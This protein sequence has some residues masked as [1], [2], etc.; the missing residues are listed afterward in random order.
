MF[1]SKQYVK[2]AGL[3][4]KSTAFKPHGLNFLLFKI[5]ILLFKNKCNHNGLQNYK[6]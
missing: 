1:Y 2:H 6:L 5:Q 4:L 3:W